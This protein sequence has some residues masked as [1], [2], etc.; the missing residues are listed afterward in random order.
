LEAKL[1]LMKQK[2]D[3]SPSGSGASTPQPST[4]DDFLNDLLPIDASAG[5]STTSQ[6]TVSTKTGT[7]EIDSVKAGLPARPYFESTEPPREL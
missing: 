6:G 5:P 1:A 7:K 3:A 4:A 2:K